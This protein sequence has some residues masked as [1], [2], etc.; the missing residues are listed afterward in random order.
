MKDKLKNGIVFLQETHSVDNLENDW[1]LN[2]DG[3]IHFSH[4]TSNSTGCAIA[5]SKN[6]SVEVINQSNDNSGRI[7]ILEVLIN[8]TKFL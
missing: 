3:D 6:F 7:L 1:K 2:W 4:G 8:D 5:F